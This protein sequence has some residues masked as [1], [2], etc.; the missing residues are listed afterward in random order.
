MEPKI[1][2]GKT[3][4]EGQQDWVMYGNE[5][6]DIQIDVPFLLETETL[7]SLLHYDKKLIIMPELKGEAT[8]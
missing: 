6:A 1:A 5:G 3:D 7:T 4:F 2:Y 8:I